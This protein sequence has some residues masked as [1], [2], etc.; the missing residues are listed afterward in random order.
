MKNKRK[1]EKIIKGDH[2]EK[3][4]VI[5]FSNYFSH[6]SAKDLEEIMEWLEDNSYLSEKGKVFRRRFWEL[7]IKK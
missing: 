7:F 5:P 1:K 4:N 2:F 3:K 6:I